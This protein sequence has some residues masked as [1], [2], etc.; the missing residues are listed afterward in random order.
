MKNK[1]DMES[2]VEFY[3]KYASTIKWTFFILAGIGLLSSLIMVEESDGISLIF[4]I[5]GGLCLAG[6]G[7]IMSNSFKW[8]A[9][10]LQN[11]IDINNK[12]K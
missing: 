1:K 3:L 9:Y 2:V 6:E 11:S 8:K 5:I 12:V 7:I 10:M 4:G